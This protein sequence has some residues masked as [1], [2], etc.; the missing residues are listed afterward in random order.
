MESN[1]EGLR[2]LVN[3]YCKG[4]P[5]KMIKHTQT[6]PRHLPTS[7]LNVLPFCGVGAIKG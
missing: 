6:I 7:S 1:Y 2:D 3:I 5:H 4:E